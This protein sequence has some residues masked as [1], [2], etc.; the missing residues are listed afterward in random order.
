MIKIYYN[1]TYLIKILNV[2]V[3][4]YYVLVVELKLVE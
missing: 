3:L 4:G 1:I 2:S